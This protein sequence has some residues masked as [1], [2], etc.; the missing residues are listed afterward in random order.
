MFPAG[1]RRGMGDPD[2]APR[3]LRRYE[4]QKPF[5]NPDVNGGV[6]HHSAPGHV[7][8][9]G[10]E[11]GLHQGDDLPSGSTISARGGMTSRSEMNETSIVASSTRSPMSSSVR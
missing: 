6:A 4:V 5:Q 8:P 9:S 1:P 2:Y 3:G 7:L 11:L 10:L